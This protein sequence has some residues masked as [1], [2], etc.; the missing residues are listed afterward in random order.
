M[1]KHKRNQLGARATSEINIE[2]IKEILGQLGEEGF[3]ISEDLDPSLMSNMLRIALNNIVNDMDAA[4][5]ES[6]SPAV[7][8]HH[9]FLALAQ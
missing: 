3:E 8:L 9:W 7:D 5:A 6:Q 2:F 4:Q 1:A